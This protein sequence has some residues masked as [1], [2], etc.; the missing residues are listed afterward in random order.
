MITKGKAQ[1]IA[2]WIF[3]ETANNTSQGNWYTYFSEIEDQFPGTKMDVETAELI[4]DELGDLYGEALLEGP[5]IDAEDESISV[6]IGTWYIEGYE[7]EWEEDTE[8]TRPDGPVSNEF[9]RDVVN[10]MVTDAIVTYAGTSKLTY[11]TLAGW[12]VE[13]T[14][15]NPQAAGR[16]I[17]DVARDLYGEMLKEAK[18]SAAGISIRMKDENHINGYAL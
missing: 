5:E 11:T 12:T 6:T 1:D 14:L 2:N 8:G 18:Y 17:V 13:G 7:P 3:A 16:Y 4:S 10:H 9:A 15:E